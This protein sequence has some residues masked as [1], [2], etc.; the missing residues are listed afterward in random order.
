MTLSNANSLNYLN[1]YR[2]HELKFRPFRDG[3]YDPAA[4]GHTVANDSV[5]GRSPVFSR[6]TKIDGIGGKSAVFFEETQV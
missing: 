4:G 1:L 2:P 5:E 3:L 6:K